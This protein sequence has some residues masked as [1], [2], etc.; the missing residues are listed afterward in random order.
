[1]RRTTVWTVV[2]LLAGGLACG[3]MGSGGGGGGSGSLTSQQLRE[4]QTQY[5]NMYELIR[6]ERPMWLQT[7][8]SVSFQDPSASLP[9]V[10]VDGVEQG[11]PPALRRINPS[12]VEEA[13][14]M[15]ASDATTRYGTGYPG[16]IIRVST[17]G[18]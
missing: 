3:S 4:L 17:R 15:S 12:D 11:E 13:E 2:L 6:S 9:R 7:R 18:G 14:F 16:G 10:F 5:D 8:G 1:M